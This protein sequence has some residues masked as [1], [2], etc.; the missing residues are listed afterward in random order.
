VAKRGKRDQGKTL[1]VKL[2]LEE[3]PLGNVS[4]VNDAWQ[5]S[6]KKGTISGTLINKTRSQL[7]LTGNLR[8]RPRKRAV[9]AGESPAPAVKRRGRKPKIAAPAA[10][11][12]TAARLDMRGR[13]SGRTRNLAELEAEIDRLLFKV[14]GMG[15]MT[16]IE[17]G[18]RKA[19]RLLF[20]AQTS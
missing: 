9:E 3:N 17:E 11:S 13:K 10:V 15:E 12:G 8:G 20:A 5:A 14:M 7:G 18:L 6:G 19:R 2:F 16:E 4:A 1:F